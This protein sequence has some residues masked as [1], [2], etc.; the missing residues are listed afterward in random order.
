[1]R[2]KTW[3]ILC[4]TFLFAIVFTVLSARADSSALTA[5]SLHAPMHD[6]MQVSAPR[7]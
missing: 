4:A 5:T 1:M 2:G 3:Y 7:I 6:S